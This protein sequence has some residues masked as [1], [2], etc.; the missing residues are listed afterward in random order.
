MR[1]V[2]LTHNFPRWPGDMSGSFLLTLARGLAERGHEITV[3]APSDEGQTFEPIV[4][5]I[6][7]RRVRYASPE[8]ETLAYRGT[9]ASAIGTLGGIRRMFGLIRSLRRAAREELARADLL[10]VH[11]WVPG[12]VA[13]PPESRYVLTVHGS[14]AMLLTRSA[15]A[16]A[17]A[18]PVIGRARVVTA[19]STALARV[20]RQRC[21]REVPPEMIHAMPLDASSLRPQEGGANGLVVVG[22]LS[23]QKRVDLAVRAVALL[24]DSGKPATLAVVGDG[25][26]RSG[27]ERLCGSLRLEELVTFHG[28]VSP[29]QVGPILARHEV[30]LFPARAEGLGLV[31][32]EALM[33][34]VSVVACS[35][36]GGVLDIVPHQ[37]GGAGGG[38]VVAPRAESI[39]AAARQLLDLPPDRRLADALELGEEWRRRLDP[40]VVAA[41][42][43]HWYLEALRAA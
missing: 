5:G 3:V 14:D 33:T 15:I 41:L 13:A 4:E 18:R 16:R 2:F 36:G 1:I 9:M 22:R 34:G 38:R 11:W 32:A 25:P 39:A 23:G 24:R 20:I 31:A 8:N 7:V 19:V 10:H 27:L 43:E 21:G 37:E 26:Q 6:T 28:Q 35:D 12:G 40:A 17:V 29:E 42:C 30:M